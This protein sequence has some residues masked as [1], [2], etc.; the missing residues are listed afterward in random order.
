MA[1]PASLN[2][3]GLRFVKRSREACVPETRR[4]AAVVRRDAASWTGKRARG[5]AAPDL[6][7]FQRI[8]NGNSKFFLQCEAAHISVM[9]LVV[10]NLGIGKSS[11]RRQATGQSGQARH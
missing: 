10:V 4:T 1:I 6:D 9:Q 8:D 5:G 11:R 2:V 7:R 3:T